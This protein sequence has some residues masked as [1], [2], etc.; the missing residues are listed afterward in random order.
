M[1]IRDWPPGCWLPPGAEPQQLLK[2]LSAAVRCKGGARAR[3]DQSLAEQAQVSAPAP[4]CPS[5][6]T[7]PTVRLVSKQADTEQTQ[8]ERPGSFIGFWLGQGPPF[9]I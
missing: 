1:V 7:V 8:S 3:Q 6:A 5:H 4:P 9:I 2:S